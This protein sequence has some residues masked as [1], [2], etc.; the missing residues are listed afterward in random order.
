MYSVS[1][2]RL[3]LELTLPDGTVRSFAPSSR[4][5]G[6]EGCER[7]EADEKMSQGRLLISSPIRFA[8]CPL[9]VFIQV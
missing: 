4:P 3:Y 6:D 2:C 1:A 9:L 8:D 5:A 7:G